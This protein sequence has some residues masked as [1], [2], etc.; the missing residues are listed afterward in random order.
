MPLAR[1]AKTK[2]ATP[3]T[4]VRRCHSKVESN[5]GLTFQELSTTKVSEDD[6]EVQPDY[7]SLGREWFMKV[8]VGMDIFKTFCQH[9]GEVE[10]TLSV[11]EGDTLKEIQNIQS[12][13]EG[14]MQIEVYMIHLY[15]VGV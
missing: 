7:V 10:S 15:F 13:F 9:L 2:R 3:P 11:L 14:R 6:V 1:N 8:D 4:R 12:D 5:E